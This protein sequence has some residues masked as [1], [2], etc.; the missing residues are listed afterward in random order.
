MFCNT[1]CDLVYLY[2]ITITIHI[3]P[4]LHYHSKGSD[5]MH[6]SKNKNYVLYLLLLLS[7][8]IG[9][10]YVLNFIRSLSENI[11][12][13]LP[14]D[15]SFIAMLFIFGFILGIDHLCR[16]KNK[17]G[18]FEIDINR[19]L[20]LGIPF[21]IIVLWY[22]LPRLIMSIFSLESFYFIEMPYILSDLMIINLSI[23]LL[24]WVIPTSFHKK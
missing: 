10:S 20:Y 24:G 17:S 21:S 2:Y 5:F 12:F 16:E 15:I 3:N 6:L 7:F 1:Y 23:I 13:S 4:V 22:W 11:I 9:G 14:Y 8:L 18:R 19:L